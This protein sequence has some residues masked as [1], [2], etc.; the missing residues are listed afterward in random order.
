M[1]EGVVGITGYRGVIGSRLFHRLVAQGFEVAP[2]EGD[3]RDGSSVSDWGQTVSSVIHC[4][5][6]VP[7]VQVS[8]DLERAIQ[9]NVVGTYNVAAL[10]RGN[11]D[12]RVMYLSTSHVYE[13]Q[14]QAISEAASCQPSSLYG[15]T[16]RQG[17][18]WIS[19]LVEDHQIVRIFS[20]FAGDQGSSYLLPGLVSRIM[21]SKENAV[22][23]LMGASAQRDI[24]DADWVVDVVMALWNSDFKGSINCGSGI[25]WSIMDIANKTAS[26]IGRDDVKFAPQNPSVDIDCIVADTSKIRSTLGGLPEFDMDTALRTAVSKLM[27]D[28]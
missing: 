18:E 14:Q 24:T 4:A 16:K 2:F 27:A 10:A 17:E 25:A 5:A 1:L 20:Y 13:R 8:E 23:P 28:D 19:E 21:A 11:P 15:L 7:T 26:I 22:L 9:T 12:F 6:L 3:V